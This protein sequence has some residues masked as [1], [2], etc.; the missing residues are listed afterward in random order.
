MLSSL[1]LIIQPI[2]EGCQRVRTVHADR[3]EYSLVRPRL[4]LGREKE[5]PERGDHKQVE[6]G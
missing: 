6:E 2:P 5:K 3:F 4:L 1:I